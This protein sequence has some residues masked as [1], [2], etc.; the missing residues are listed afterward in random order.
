[1]E[2][3]DSRDLAGDN[4]G[5][6]VLLRDRL[7]RILEQIAERERDLARGGVHLLDFDFDLFAFFEDVSWML[8][9]IPTHLADVDQAIDAAEIDER[10]KV[11]QAAHNPLALLTDFEFGQQLAAGFF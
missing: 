7:P 3:H 11:A 10:A 2:L 4:R 6:G 1:A 8:D 5:D 9:A